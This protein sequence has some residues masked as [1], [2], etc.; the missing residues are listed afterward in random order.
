MWHGSSAL[1]L[2]PLCVQLCSMDFSWQEE[3]QICHKVSDE[4][5]FS[6][7]GR[8]YVC[9]LCDFY[10]ILFYFAPLSLLAVS[11]RHM[12]SEH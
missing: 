8:V 6:D 10:I 2:C 1:C 4:G 11:R 9:L 12:E 3:K 5:I 7:L